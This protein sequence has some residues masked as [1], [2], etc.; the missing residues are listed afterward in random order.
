M[1]RDIANL[2]A[3]TLSGIVSASTWGG[4]GADLMPAPLASAA[5][6]ASLSNYG[7]LW[8]AGQEGQIGGGLDQPLSPYSQSLWVYRC[9]SEIQRCC[10]GIPIRQTRENE[11]VSVRRKDWTLTFRVDAA[12]CRVSSDRK[13]R[14]KMP[15]LHCG[16]RP[17][18]GRKAV[19]VGKAPDGEEITSGEAV[20]LLAR[21][22]SYQDWPVFFGALIGYYYLSGKSAIVLSGMDGRGNRPRE[23]HV[24]NGKHITPVWARDD[25][26]QPWL[27]GY[28]YRSPRSHEVV[29]L[30]LDE[31][32]FFAS[33]NPDSSDPLGGLAAVTPGKLA[34]ASEYN[35]SLYN[36]TSLASGGEPGSVARFPGLLT[37][38]QRDQFR[39][40]YRDRFQG[41]TKAK[42]LLI[43]EGGGEVNPFSTSLRDM[44]WPEGKKISRLEIC[45]LLGVPPVVAGW[46]DAAG[47]SSAYTSNSLRQFY[48]QTVFPLLDI[49]CPAIQE[50]V[51]R[52]DATAVVYF[53]VEDQPV[54]QEMRLAR[55]DSAVKFFGLGYPPNM[56]N[57]QL[58]LGMEETEWGDVGLLPAGLMPA[59]DVVE[60]I[61]F[62][63][64]NEGPLPGEPGG[65][66]EPSVDA[67]SRRG[68]MPRLL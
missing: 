19:L 13:E 36:A 62:P 28:E 53:D 38:E 60:G 7:R 17:L 59:Q 32:K 41:P 30:G 49:F 68:G 35:A 12:S 2:A 50:I 54:V 14:G 42:R 34:I 67:A 1:D 61:V 65:D 37:P 3:D 51:S 22:N 46:V 39:Q 47:D 20:D 40:N 25:S 11:T 58:D 8:L 55:L 48:Q 16:L 45:C 24:V 9:L 4:S 6:D 31:V 15:R 66:G 43:I 56:I 44:E 10:G 64:V 26:D 29:P 5:K 23:L 18:K 33:W 57:R 52:F 63:P 21:P 27:L